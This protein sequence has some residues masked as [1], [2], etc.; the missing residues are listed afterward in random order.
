V[1]I[2]LSAVLKTGSAGE[3]EFDVRGDASD[4]SDGYQASID[5][6]HPL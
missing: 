6:R 2:G 1:D 5:Y 3:F 4:T